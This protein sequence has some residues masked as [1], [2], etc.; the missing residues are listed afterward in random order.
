MNGQH[1]NLNVR[2]GFHVLTQ[3]INCPLNKLPTMTDSASEHTLTDKSDYESPRAATPLGDRAGS[4]LHSAAWAT[5]SHTSFACQ[6]ILPF[7]VCGFGNLGAGQLINHI[8]D[9]PVFVIV[10]ELYV[11]IPSLMGLKGNLEM[12]MASRLS[13]AANCGVMDVGRETLIMAKGNLA[14]LQCQAT[15]VGFLAAV[16]A[17][18]VDIY[19]DG[20]EVNFNHAL[21]MASASVIT[22]NLT[23][24]I[25]SMVMIA[26]VIYSRKLRI[27]PDNISTPIASSLGDMTT[28]AVLAYISS[29]FFS[30]IGPNFWWAPAVMLVFLCVSPLTAYY[31]YRNKYTNRV[32][33]YGWG[34]IILAMIISS[35]GGIILDKSMSIFPAVAP[36]QPVINGVGGN[37]VAIQASRISTYLHQRLKPGKLPQDD[38]RIFTTPCATFFGRSSDANIARILFA[39]ATPAHVLYFYV[40]HS[41]QGDQVTALFA[42]IYLSIA[43]FE[44]IFLLYLAR[45]LVYWLWERSSDPDDSAIPLLTATGDLVGTGLILLG[46][47]GLQ[48]VNQKKV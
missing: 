13:T 36:F 10:P 15:V 5:E 11:L 33:S 35:I 14:L 20:G 12:T 31:A 9:W 43:L 22:A 44:V 47:Y 37:L 34:P 1:A 21:L 8:K 27:N 6:V 24:V 32:I 40:I 45:I 48:F 42:T 18:F 23:S 25:L 26:V 2:Q 30:L 41:I 46:F 39:M 7:L 3:L 4:F 28:V 38:D 19:T 16:V 17:I 29:Y